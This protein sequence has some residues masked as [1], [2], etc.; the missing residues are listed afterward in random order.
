MDYQL[1]FYH[2]FDIDGGKPVGH[3]VSTSNA[4]D[5]FVRLK[6]MNAL[7]IQIGPSF[8]L[9][10]TYRGYGQFAIYGHIGYQI[11]GGNGIL[12]YS[13]TKDS[14]SGQVSGFIS[15]V[16]LSFA[17]KNVGF[18]GEY[19][20]RRHKASLTYGTNLKVFGFNSTTS[21]HG[22]HGVGVRIFVKIGK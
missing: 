13:Y 17:I 20:Y 3:A 6:K 22:D 1:L 16:G 7:C 10:P 21:G 19:T 9:T 15:T 8:T 12:N 14:V 4:F 18:A 11:G 5:A 2:Y